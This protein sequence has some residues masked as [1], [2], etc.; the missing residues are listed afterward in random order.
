MGKLQV[1]SAK[2]V[3]SVC[4]AEQDVPV[5]CCGTAVPGPDADKLFCPCYPEG[6]HTESAAR[7]THCGQPMKYTA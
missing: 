3:C 1:A 4:R 2:L 6:G 7:P 5:V